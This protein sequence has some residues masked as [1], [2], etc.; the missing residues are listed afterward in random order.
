MLSTTTW[1][2]KQPSKLNQTITLVHYD[3]FFL[4][5]GEEIYVWESQEIENILGYNDKKPN[6]LN[7]LIKACKYKDVL[8]LWH[9][10]IIGSNLCFEWKNVKLA[11]RLEH[12][13][14]SCHDFS[15]IY[16]LLVVHVFLHKLYWR[17][18]WKV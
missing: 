13:A 2:Y 8:S 18:T 4:S 15:H 3:V 1:I 9:K 11:F 12:R 17:R 14:H 16:K 5:K 6:A 10:P 7:P